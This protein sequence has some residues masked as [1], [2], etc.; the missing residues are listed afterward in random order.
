MGPGFVRVSY[1]VGEDVRCT[2]ESKDVLK[3]VV[4]EDVSM[5][6]DEGVDE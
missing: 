4:N 3:S 2:D 6:A 5:D 1:P